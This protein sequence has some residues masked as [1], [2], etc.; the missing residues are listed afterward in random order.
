MKILFV[1]TGNA[2]RSPLAEALMKK[3][4]PDWTVDSAGLNLAIPVA[5]QIRY[6]LA[7]ESAEKHL[8]KAP[9]SIHNK[10]LDTYDLIVAME[11]RHR[12]YILA[13]CPECAPKT[14]V[15]SIADPYFMSKH[16]AEKIYDRIKEKVHEL[17]KSR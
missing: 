6:Y 4:R 10:P 16:D 1:C 7:S 17:A 3:A 12:T 11:E 15:W 13:I 8:K 9:E 2:H 5:T 14:L